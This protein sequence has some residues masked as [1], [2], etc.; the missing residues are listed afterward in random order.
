MCSNKAPPSDCIIGH[1]GRIKKLM[2]TKE[3][4]TKALIICN[5]YG[6]KAQ[7]IKCCEELSELETAILHHVNKG[8]NEDSILEEMADV[9]IMLEQMRFML[10]Y[11]EAALEEKIEYKLNRQLGRIMSAD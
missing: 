4:T 5:T 6:S 11:D 10:P 2:M 8:E 9:Y 1:Y 7:M 3:Q